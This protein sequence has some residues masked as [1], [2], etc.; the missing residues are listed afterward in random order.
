MTD[1][2]RI[3]LAQTNPVVGDI[4]GNAAKI[5]RARDEAARQGADLVVYTELVLA[6]YPPEDLVLKPSFQAEI[7]DAVEKLA[8]VTGD[9]GPALLIGAPW[10]DNGKL[11]NA[12]LLLDGGKVAAVRFK[13]DL[14]NYGVFDEK[15]VFAAGPLPGPVNFRGVRLGV[16]V[17]EDMWTPDVTECLDESGAELLVIVNGSPFDIGKARR[18]AQP[19]RRARRRSNPAADLC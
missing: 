6:G 9:G 19:R 12:A 7:E 10:R 15:R 13:Y 4:Q 18:Q 14:P 3:A 11:Y 16:M 1:I 8:P 2:L 17:C 5:L